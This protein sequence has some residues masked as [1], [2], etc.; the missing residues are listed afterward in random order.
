MAALSL[1]TLNVNG[2]RDRSKRSRVFQFCR[3][4]GAD[5][6]FLQ[7]THIA[8]DDDVHLWS[9][10]WGGGFFASIGTQMS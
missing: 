4:L 1:I 10:E 5:V 9:Y 7:E 3:Q 6:V 8:S 2:I